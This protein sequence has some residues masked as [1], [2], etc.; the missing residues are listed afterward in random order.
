MQTTRMEYATNRITPIIFIIAGVIVACFGFNDIKLAIE[1]SGWP[2]TAGTVLISEVETK[3]D[4]TKRTGRK[5]SYHARVQY[6]FKVN[7][8]TYTGS[9]IAFGDHGSSD[10]KPA[11]SI[12][13]K[14]RKG[15]AI[16]VAYKKEDPDECVIETGIQRKTWFLSSLGLMASAFGA[17]LF[18]RK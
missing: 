10:Q 11:R 4:R 1:S 8:I 14:Y 18:F 13:K 7:G 12:V 6:E 5:V 16:E 3:T 15:K 2:R 17:V 9:R